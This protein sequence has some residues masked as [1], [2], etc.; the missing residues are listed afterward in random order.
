M[1]Y[2]FFK[3]VRCIDDRHFAP[4][5]IEVPGTPVYA[6]GEKTTSKYPLFGFNDFE[7]AKSFAAF[8]CALESKHIIIV[9]GTTEAE[10]FRID[11]MTNYL[12]SSMQLESFSDIEYFW[13][14]IKEHGSFDPEIPFPFWQAHPDY[15]GCYDFTPTHIKA[16]FHKSPYLVE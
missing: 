8:R 15:Y 9:E 1:S 6:L 5:V 2:P 16:D 3:V 10:P 12:F 7:T 11:T 13:N 4:A 14:H